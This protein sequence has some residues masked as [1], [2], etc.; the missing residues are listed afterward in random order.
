[1]FK[2][3]PRFQNI[4]CTLQHQWIVIIQYH[5]KC[6]TTYVHKTMSR[7][8]SIYKTSHFEA[9]NEVKP[10]LNC[11]ESFR[12]KTTFMFSTLDLFT[13]QCIVLENY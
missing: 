10:I 3:D 4:K 1:M 12:S 13:Y 6:E 5:C 7:T 11:F 8:K 9:L 2:L